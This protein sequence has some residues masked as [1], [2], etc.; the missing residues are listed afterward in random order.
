MRPRN[1]WPFCISCLKTA[2][3]SLYT[4]LSHVRITRTAILNIKPRRPTDSNNSS[5]PLHSFL[6]PPR[7]YVFVLGSLGGWSVWRI[8]QKVMDEL[9]RMFSEGTGTRNSRLAMDDDL[10][11]LWIRDQ[12]IRLHFCYHCRRALY[13]CCELTATGSPAYIAGQGE[14]HSG[15]S[16][17]GKTKKTGLHSMR[18]F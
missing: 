1:V 15:K 8:T 14:S 13:E 9:S 4:A 7:R 16:Q 12:E 10:I 2:T 17:Y 18:T 6:P 11:C 3:S 5:H